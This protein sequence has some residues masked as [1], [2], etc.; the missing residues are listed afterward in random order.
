MNASRSDNYLRMEAERQ[1]YRKYHLPSRGMI[2]GDDSPSPL[3]EMLNKL[4][5][6]EPPALSAAPAPCPRHARTKNSLP[7]TMGDRSEAENLSGTKRSG[8]ESPSSTSVVPSRLPSSK[9]LRSTPGGESDSNGDDR[10]VGELKKVA[11]QVALHLCDADSASFEDLKALE[12]R[13]DWESL[14]AGLPGLRDWTE[15]VPALVHEGRSRHLRWVEETLFTKDRPIDWVAL[16]EEHDLV[17]SAIAG[18]HLSVVLFLRSKTGMSDELDEAEVLEVAE[19]VHPDGK[20]ATYYSARA[21]MA[22]R[23]TDLKAM[24]SA[25]MTVE[26]LVVLIRNHLASGNHT[27]LADLKLTS[28]QMDDLRYLRDWTEDIPAAVGSG[29][30]ATL[31]WLVDCLFVDPENTV[32]FEDLDKKYGLIQLAQKK[33]FPDMVHHLLEERGLG[34][35]MCETDIRAAVARAQLVSDAPEQPSERNEGEDEE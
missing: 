21:D 33:G 6:S 23:C 26:C 19:S 11:R 1:E 29:C 8:T 3:E 17:P 35:D 25:N 15:F 32:C 12:S 34:D 7:S 2:T 22:P 5:V 20:V 27:A 10:E 4:P 9:A 28:Q 14:K 13:D 16:E 24:V 30:V 31:D 18:D